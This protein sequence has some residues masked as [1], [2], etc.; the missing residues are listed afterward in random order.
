M[1]VDEKLFRN[2]VKA[3]SGAADAKLQGA[4]VIPDGYPSE[5]DTQ[6]YPHTI[7]VR[8]DKLTCKYIGAGN[9]ANDFGSVR[10]ENSVPE[11]VDIYY[12][13][14]TIIDKGVTGSIAVGLSAQNKDLSLQVGTDPVSESYGYRGDDGKKYRSGPRGESSQGESSQY[15]PLFSAGDVV[16]CGISATTNAVFFTKNGEFL[17]NAFEGVKGKLYPTVSL[18]SRDEMVRINL[19]E[20]EF[21]F[22]VDGHRRAEKA[23]LEKLVQATPVDE[24]ALGPLIREYLAHS[25]YVNALK[26]FDR[27]WGHES[28]RSSML[29]NGDAKLAR[30]YGNFAQEKRQVN[31]GF[32]GCSSGSTISSS[33]ESN[34]P[35][36]STAKRVKPNHSSSEGRLTKNRK[37]CNK[38]NTEE[39]RMSIDSNGDAKMAVKMESCDAIILDRSGVESEAKLFERENVR[40]LII[41]GE[42]A[43]AIEF[44]QAT[45]PKVL[46]P[47]LL[48]ALHCQQFVEF[49]R[50]GKSNQGIQFARERFA[51]Q[52]SFTAEQKKRLH[53]IMGLVA[54]IDLANSPVAHLLDSE[55]R[56]NLAVQVNSSIMSSLEL[57]PQSK[58]EKILRHLQ[59]VKEKQRK[60]NN[61]L[62]VP[63]SL[64]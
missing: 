47:S 24:N 54:Y 59:A 50:Q 34:N 58:L 1:D 10:T 41:N 46:T 55:H 63:F 40:K 22:D 18:H 60:K 21:Q 62:G 20:R 56:Q 3:T 33:S 36:G 31:G 37:T 9:H 26:T 42:I 39:W 64:V 17:S 13:E 16:G 35:G 51:R 5:I 52:G 32:G 53:Q 19:G 2:G 27:A 43:K 44:L 7:E 8:K 6:N 28:K 4:G 12:F 29:R 15:G 11:A 49:M 61:G 48:F 25:S 57:S 45:F 30:H 38:E 14:V 23:K